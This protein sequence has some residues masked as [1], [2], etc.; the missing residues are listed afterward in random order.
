M[1]ETV[2]ELTVIV[3]TWNQGDLLKQC[4]ASL[5]VQSTPC[6]VLV[7]DNGSEVSIQSLIQELQPD[8]SGRLSW[9]TLPTNLGFAGAVNEGI[10]QCRTAFVA[11]L[12]NDTEADP[13]WAEAGLKA[14]RE[15][16]EYSFF[17]SRLVQYHHRQLLD[18]AGDEY[19]RM[20][21]PYKRGRGERV[22]NYLKSK[23][24]LG[25]CGAAAFYQRPLFDEIGLFDES[26]FM[27]LEDVDWSLRAHLAGHRCLYLP[28][29]VVYHIEAAS[30]PPGKPGSL[31][32][33]AGSREASNDPGS[34][35]LEPPPSPNR[36][37]WIT[38]NRW[39]L[40]VTYQPWQNLP[41]ILWGWIRSG[42]HYLVNSGSLR[43][44]LLGLLAGVVAT[45]RAW[46]K[47]LN[48]RQSRQVPLREIY[49]KR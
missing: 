30:D 36:I 42:G 46:R 44:F 18:G 48:L 47:R 32:G 27:Y 35:S 38:R 28:E 12:N 19:D 1:L 37:Y 10:R 13:G 14:L 25:A 8:F 7:V 5:R 20:G 23:A 4:L 39:Q 45:P 29:A 26:F 11:L 31:E 6:L 40:M 22:D 33:A 43:A 24:V 3:P 9:I 41:W 34:P 16:A 21:I 15:Q 17:S 2:S 49:R